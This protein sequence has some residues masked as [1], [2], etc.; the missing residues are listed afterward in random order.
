M[1]KSFGVSIPMNTTLRNVSGALPVSG[2]GLTGYG[3]NQNSLI[4]RL[5]QI[6]EERKRQAERED[7]LR[8]EIFRLHPAVRKRGGNP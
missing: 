6:D 5:L 3:A 7:V 4:A 2:H 1:V 8:E